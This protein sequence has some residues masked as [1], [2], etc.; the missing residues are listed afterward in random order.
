MTTG[1]IRQILTRRLGPPAWLDVD[2]GDLFPVLAGGKQKAT[3]A[4]APTPNSAEQQAL[5]VQTQI[6]QQQLALAREQQSQANQLTPLILSQ[7]GYE[8]TPGTQAGE[9]QHVLNIGGTSYVVGRSSS[10][11]ALDDLNN[12]IATESGQR[13][14][15]GL[16]GE[17]PVDP[18]VEQDLSRREQEIRERLLRQ[19]GPGYEQSDPG[20]RALEEFKRGAN[21]IRYQVR[22]G[23]MSSANAMS[24]G[25]QNL[26]EGRRAS[27]AGFARSTQ[28]PYQLT[29]GLLG[30]SAS[31]AGSLLDSGQRERFFN[32]QLTAQRR[33]G[34]AAM[35]GQGVS[36][37]VGAGGAIGGAIIL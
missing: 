9:G 37:L 33:A 36:G 35:I 34:N 31:T 6:M 16:R 17:I 15:A 32:T 18:A 10:D 29:A 20:I 24:A 26:I 4:P 11:R 27:S 3:Q 5:Q 12:Q 2:T 13:T 8:V 19:L 1:L 14:L 23:E 22:H 30:Q 21:S 25:A 7:G 28:D